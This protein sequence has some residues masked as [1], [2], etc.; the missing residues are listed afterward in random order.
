[1]TEG[2]RSS[3]WSV[4]GAIEVASETGAERYRG[5]RTVFRTWSCRIARIMRTAS[6][7]SFG[8]V[9]RLFRNT[10]SYKNQKPRA[11]SST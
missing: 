10:R 9:A 6:G 1:M 4:I 3:K 2:Q 7:V 5:A 11:V 8:C